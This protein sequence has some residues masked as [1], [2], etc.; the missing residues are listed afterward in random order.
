M[1]EER[2]I[3]LVKSLLNTK[4]DII[5]HMTAHKTTFRTKIVDYYLE[6]TKCEPHWYTLSI[7]TL[8]N[9]IYIHI[10]DYITTI[11]LEHRPL[12]DQLYKS[13]DN[14]VS[15]KTRIIGEIINE[16]NKH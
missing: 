6:I 14:K 4:Q 12:F 11:N 3:E 15:E 16:L 8:K 10:L 1:I 5:W 7:F 2:V 9:G 13:I